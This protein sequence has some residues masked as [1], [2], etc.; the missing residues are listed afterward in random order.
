MGR[1]MLQFMRAWAWMQVSQAAG[2]RGEGALPWVAKPK[3]DGVGT[4]REQAP[5]PRVMFDGCALFHGYFDDG[6][7]SAVDKAIVPRL[8]LLTLCECALCL[9]GGGNALGQA[10]IRLGAEEDI[11]FLAPRPPQDGWDAASLTQL[12][13]DTRPDA[14]INLAY[15]FDWF[16]AESGQRERLALRSVPSSVWP[17]CASIT[18]SFWCNLPATVFS[19]ARGRP[20]TAKKTNRC[21]W[22]CVVRRC[23]ASNKACVRRAR[24]MC[25]CVFGWLLDDSA[26]GTLGR[27]S[28]APNPGRTVDG[29]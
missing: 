19:T 20:P 13:D 25:C 21:R 15:Y 14:L 4:C 16:Q 2:D 28:L 10:L 17:N 9:L 11:G 5:S 22:A 12:L 7:T 23:G 26:D 8:S 24:S 18:T 3:P 1:F 29:R 6:A 27:F